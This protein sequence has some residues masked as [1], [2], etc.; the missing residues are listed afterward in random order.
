MTSSA[1]HT[2]TRCAIWFSPEPPRNYWC[3]SALNRNERDAVAPT[4]GEDL[5]GINLVDLVGIEPTTSSMPWKRAPSCATGPLKGHYFL[6]WMTTI[7]FADCAQIVNA[8]TFTGHSRRIL[9]SSRRHREPSQD[10]CEIGG[11]GQRMD[12]CN[13]MFQR[14]E[15]VLDRRP[16]QEIHLLASSR[17]L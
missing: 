13:L 5:L 4:F 8:S 6:C 17:G 3:R 1:L 16:A 10:F 9:R 14:G 2:L 15:R 11:M 12:K 7:I